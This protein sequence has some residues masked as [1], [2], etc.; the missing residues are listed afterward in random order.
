MNSNRKYTRFG[1]LGIPL[2]WLLPIC[3]VTA[4]LAFLTQTYYWDGVLFSLDIEGVRR[5]DF[6]AAILFHPN[7]LLYSAAGYAVYST[8]LACGL[9]ARAITILQVFN[10]FASAL[11]G[12]ILYVIARRL[13]RSSSIA[14][15]SWLL[16]AFGAN[17]WKYST[18]ADSY[19]ISVLLLLLAAMFM[20]QERPGMVPVGVCH[21][22]AMLFHELAVF[23]FVPILVATAFNK[24]LSKRVRIYTSTVYVLFCSASIAVLYVL[25]YARADHKTYPTLLSWITSYASNSGFTRTFGQIAG[26]YLGGYV[27]LVAGGKLV[28]LR[29]YFSAAVCVS[30]CIC[31][32]A[33]I[34]AMYLWR[35]PSK[36][37]PARAPR[38][39]ITFLWLWFLTYA[40]FLASFDPG[41]TFHLLFLWPPI[42]LLIAVYL[43]GRAAFRERA[44]MFI[45]IAV[46][47]AAWN[48]AAFIYPHSHASA[49]PV[50][51][52]AQTI[53]KQLPRNATIY[54]R[55][56]DADD[57]Y[58]QYFAPGRHWLPMP[59]EITTAQAIAQSASGP[60][61]LETTALDA[62]GLHVDSPQKWDL[63]NNR[64][65]VR[66]ECLNKVR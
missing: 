30:L 3:I 63:V 22:L 6:P 12:G 13:T 57:W 46:S 14:L 65:N 39:S 11:A 51:A 48:F 32:G 62:L 44:G 33:L 49:D 52:L 45:A 58:L 10:V 15:F 7:H 2:V 38:G 16:F 66:L 35:H 55:E 9:H 47:I 60:V 50:L 34:Y 26:S 1:G 42:V 37:A 56:L 8:A 53:D 64:H 18:D 21:V 23:T 41:S 27:K 36:D 20:L 40:V 17:W 43:A 24:R 61:C 59:R 5:G 31:V 29:D 25:C 28:F 19:V 4:Y 54:Y